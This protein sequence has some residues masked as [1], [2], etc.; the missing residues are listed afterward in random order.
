MNGWQS[1]IESEV[2]QTS[3]SSV[4]LAY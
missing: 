1:S 3:S 2:F 4:I